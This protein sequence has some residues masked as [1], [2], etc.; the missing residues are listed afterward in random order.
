MT[1]PTGEAPAA[2]PVPHCYRHPD[3][4]TYISCTR[5]ERPICPQCMIPAAVGH[6]CPTCVAEGGKTVRQPRTAVGARV[7]QG[8]PVTVAL[9]AINVVMFLLTTASAT[10]F[11]KLSLVPTAVDRHGPFLEHGQYYRLVTAMFLHYNVVHLGLN[12]YALFIMGLQLEPALG[13]WRFTTLYFVAGLGGSV[14]TYLFADPRVTEAGA[15][16]AVF[17]L[18]GA[19][20][21][22]ARKVRADLRPILWLI[23]LNLV[24]TFAFSNISRTA[25]IGG[26]LTGALV[27]ALFAYV[28]AGPR[29]ALLQ[30]LGCAAI[31]AVL[32]V[33]V[34]TVHL[35]VQVPGLP[36]GT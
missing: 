16:G 28:P 14:A 23:G 17:G 15:S 2:S 29:R 13:R 8:T 33:L 1:E 24:I 21:V 35:S 6:Q 27:G 20:A 18:F 19:L 26:L 22:L 30:A 5:C 4:E 32:A 7:A 25:H 31:V 34:L 10:L 36:A 12:M 9:I 3:R 11:D